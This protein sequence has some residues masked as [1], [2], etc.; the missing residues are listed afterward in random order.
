MIGYKYSLHDHL[1]KSLCPGCKFRRPPSWNLKD[2]SY[3]VVC[4]SGS[5]PWVIT[6]SWYHWDK[7]VEQAAQSSTP[8]CI[9]SSGTGSSEKTTHS[10]PS[11][12][13]CTIDKFKKICI[14]CGLT[15]MDLNFSRAGPGNGQVPLSTGVLNKSCVLASSE[16][17]LGTLEQM[18]EEP[19][20]KA[21]DSILAH[22]G[23][24]GICSDVLIVFDLK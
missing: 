11:N 2:P 18:R 7:F 4:A 23:P 3:R 12:P 16:L 10:G 13:N 21:I 8:L 14:E 19:V 1:L 20:L 22:A 24:N 17:Q 15:A 5:G 6:M 9:I